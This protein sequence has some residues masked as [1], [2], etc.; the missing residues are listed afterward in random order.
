MGAVYYCT[1]F[2]IF[3][4]FRNSELRAL[5]RELNEELG[6]INHFQNEPSPFLLSITPIENQVQPCK[7]HYDIW[8]LV[9]TDGH[10]FKVD[11]VEFLATKWLT[12]AEARE[13]V[14]DQGNLQALEVVEKLVK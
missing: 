5:N 4:E 2:C 3:C 14:T 6:L 10:S 11:P 9:S 8:Y 1:I 12:I 7:M 13:I